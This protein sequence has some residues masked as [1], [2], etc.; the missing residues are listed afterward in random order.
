MSVVD[1]TRYALPSEDWS[2]LL[3]AGDVI[4]VTTVSGDHV[5]LGVGFVPVG[6]T[7]LPTNAVPLCEYFFGDDIVD[8]RAAA[9]GDWSPNSNQA[10]A[11]TPAAVGPLGL[12]KPAH[13][14]STGGTIKLRL[15]SPRDDGGSPVL[16]FEV[17]QQNETSA[18]SVLADVVTY[19]PDVMWTASR[20][21]AET[22]YNFIVIALNKPTLCLVV[23]ARSLPTYASTTALSL[24]L[25]PRSLRTESATGGSI[26]FVFTAPFDDGGSPILHYEAVFNGSCTG[27]VEPA[28]I[29]NSSMPTVFSG[30][31]LSFAVYGLSPSTPFCVKVRAVTAFGVGN[32][33]ELLQANTG[34]KSL[35]SEWTR[36]AWG[37]CAVGCS[38]CRAWTRVALSVCC[39]WFEL[40]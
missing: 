8:A 40:P 3:T 38:L 32:F 22:L 31:A 34:Q 21:A 11:Y 12:R 25:P 17:Y 10:F 4:R 39:S 9:L 2:G 19:A 7:N 16:S 24:P 6:A 18:A 35:P 5:F 1:S 13:V 15:L 33:T 20:L 27:D 36:H 14:G 29:E 30:A 37:L 26:S 23:Q 28:G